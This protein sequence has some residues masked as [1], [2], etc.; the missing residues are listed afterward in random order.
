MLTMTHP[1]YGGRGLFTKLASHLFSYMRD[2]GYHS[3][4]GFPNKNSHRPFIERL[5]WQ[6]IH[7]V[8]T[9][10]ADVSRLKLPDVPRERDDSFMRDY[11][12]LSNLHS[13]ISVRK[14][15]KWLRW[16]YAENPVNTYSNHVVTDG[17]KVLAMAVTKAYQGSLDLVDLQASDGD[18][19]QRVLSMVAS[20]ARD[21]NAERIRTWMPLCHYLHLVL[22]KIGFLNEAPV[23]YMAGLCFEGADNFY[24]YREW[25]VQMGDS[26]V[27]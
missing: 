20:E 9:M 19:G 5:H 22:E 10:T 15:A 1:K 14:D 25:Y 11:S 6:D 23:T 24:D 8:P 7:E 12:F 2:E 17:E 18:T 21:R 3:V 4:W 26:D 27:Y 16:R 13:G